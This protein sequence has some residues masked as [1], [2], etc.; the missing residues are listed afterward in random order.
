MKII[1]ISGKSGSGKNA[2]A[3]AFANAL[4]D[5]RVLTIA[6][7]D[8]VK[9]FLKQYY[10]WNGEKDEAG[11]KM[12][13][14]L[15]TNKVRKMF[16]TYWAEVV[17]EFVMATAA[18]WDYVIIPDWR[19]V[20]EYYTIADYTNNTILIRVERYNEDGSKWVN[21]DMTPEQLNHISENELEKFSF[22]YIVENRGDISNLDDAAATII[23]DQHLTDK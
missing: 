3:A 17:A 20:N 12:L 23:E 8:L 18:D 22:D 4:K 1:M 16:P 15:G 2:L 5:N 19:F 21:P 11:R 13:Q 6:F 10:G 9:T 7:G 14:E